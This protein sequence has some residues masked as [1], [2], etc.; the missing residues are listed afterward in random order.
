MDNNADPIELDKFSA[1][2]RNWW[3][4]QGEFR[5]LQ[6]I[7]PTRIA[8]VEQHCQ[9][10][11]QSVVDIGCGGGVLSEGLAARGANVVGIDAAKAVIE[12][13]REHSEAAAFV[14]DYQITT[15]EQYAEEKPGCFDI[16]TCMEL[17]EHVPAPDSVVRACAKL[18]KPGGHIFFSTINR[19]WRAYGG[20][21]F[22]GEYLFS[23]LPRGTHDYQRFIKPSELAGWSRTVGL[24]VRDV[25]GMQYNPFST[26]A[27]LGRDTSVNYLLYAAS[28]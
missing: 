24:T 25:R 17:L 26:K 28:Q 8:F 16:V 13:A 18:V 9:L 11:G 4:P 10:D 2:A 15:A 20:A 3:D 23:L 14:I 7:N 12:V 27:S 21:V 22:A 5:T 19:T 1:A 6:H